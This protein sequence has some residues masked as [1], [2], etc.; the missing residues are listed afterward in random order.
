MN[1][2]FTTAPPTTG[3]RD[4]LHPDPPIT[5]PMWASSRPAGAYRAG[6]SPPYAAQV[7][8]FCN[9]GRRF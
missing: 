2:R 6:P 7:F 1:H 5:A 3:F 8:G 4:F 9:R